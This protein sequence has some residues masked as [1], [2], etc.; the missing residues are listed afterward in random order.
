MSE[1][2]LQLSVPL[3]GVLHA[4]IAGICSLQC[5]SP[6]D[7]I[8][9]PSGRVWQKA[10]GNC[11]LDIH[12]IVKRLDMMQILVERGLLSI[13]TFKRISNRRS[14]LLKHCKGCDRDFT[15]KDQ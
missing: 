9:L 11:I 13:Y 10:V 3:Q 1:G 5:H 4:G 15:R 14:S 2:G 7:I 8:F 6:L 12:P